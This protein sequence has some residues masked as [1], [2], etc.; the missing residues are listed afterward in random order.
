MLCCYLTIAWCLLRFSQGN[1]LRCGNNLSFIIFF[2]AVILVVS[3]D[4]VKTRSAY[5]HLQQCQAVHS[6]PAQN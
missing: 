4:A 1:F 5:N 3:T 2:S 6:D